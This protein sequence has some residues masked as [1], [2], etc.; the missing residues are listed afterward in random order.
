MVNTRKNRNNKQKKNKQK[1]NT[2]KK[3]HN[4]QQ[5]RNNIRKKLIMKKIFGG[6]TTQIS[7]CK[8][9]LVGQGTTKKVYKY[10]HCSSTQK[11]QLLVEIDVNTNEPESINAAILENMLLQQLQ[12]NNTVPAVEVSKYSLTHKNDKTTIS[13]FIEECGLNTKNKDEIIFIDILTSKPTNIGVNFLK[14]IIKCS[15]FQI[16]EIKHENTTLK[17]GLYLNLD[18][19]SNNFCY[20]EN[21]DNQ[22]NIPIV[23]VMDAGIDFL[24]NIETNFVLTAKLYVFILYCGLFINK[25]SLPSKRSTLRKITPVIKDISKELFKDEIKLFTNDN[26]VNNDK[27]LVDLEDLVKYINNNNKLLSLKDMLIHY[28]N[29]KT[30]N[31]STTNIIEGRIGDLIIQIMHEDF[32]KPGSDLQ[33]KAAKK[34]VLINSAN[35]IEKINVDANYPK[36]AVTRGRRSTINPEDVKF[37]PYSTKIE[38]LNHPVATNKN[39]VTPE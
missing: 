23:K 39:I 6:D 16:D 8:D 25:Y 24:H 22:N 1:K 2:Q 12:K 11:P 27:N 30:T 34:D 20:Q 33:K 28:L 18:C 32:L 10:H 31:E 9:K 17:K 35:N 21:Q 4:K 37:N 5:K 14:E 13:Y 19:K 26:N 36:K 3:R 15:I 7:I 38:F 29:M